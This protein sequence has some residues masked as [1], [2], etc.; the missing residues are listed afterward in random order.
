MLLRCCSC[1]AGLL[2]RITYPV[3]EIDDAQVTP[4]AACP[5][6]TVVITRDA[7]HRAWDTAVTFWRHARR[8]HLLDQVGC[9][10]A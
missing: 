3:C 2:H 6:D 9:D 5:G 8:D 4:A 1:P 7:A 10:A